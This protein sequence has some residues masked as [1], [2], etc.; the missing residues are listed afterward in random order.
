MV[1]VA[2]INNVTIPATAATTTRSYVPPLTSF[3]F[4]EWRK[5][6]VQIMVAD[7]FLNDCIAYLSNLLAAE[8]HF[9]KMISLSLP[10][11]R[12]NKK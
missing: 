7:Y 3:F 1:V 12:K 8:M 4:P 6:Y 10:L 2:A 9:L 5:E 11:Y